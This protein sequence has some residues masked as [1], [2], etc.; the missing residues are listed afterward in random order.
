MEPQQ[1]KIDVKV[2]NGVWDIELREGDEPKV[3]RATLTTDEVFSRIGGLLIDWTKP[4][5]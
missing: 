3:T 5:E 1:F 4:K 2:E